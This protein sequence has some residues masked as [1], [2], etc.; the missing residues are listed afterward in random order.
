[1]IMA[2]TVDGKIAKTAT[3]FPDWT[4]KE[5]KQFF[6]KESKK[7]GVVIMGGKT[8]DTFP[9]PLKER[10][11]VVITAD[12]GYENIKDSVK[13]YFK[14]SPKFVKKDLEKMGYKKAI[15]GGGAFINGLFL[16]NKLVDEII[17]IVAPKFFG[18][19]LSLSSGFDF[20]YDL[21]LLDTYKINKDSVLL[22]YKILY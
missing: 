16:K 9:R 14:K 11:N 6:A 4:S 12:K 13:V 8:F 17:I 1:M 7:A 18:E 2:T 10:L 22:R 20:N 21:K 3:H 19:G 15:L 5:D